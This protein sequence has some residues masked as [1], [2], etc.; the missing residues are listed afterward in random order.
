MQ[1][2]HHRYKIE[3]DFSGVHKHILEGYVK[4]AVGMKHFH[5]HFFYGVSSY[6]DHAHSY[7]GITGIPISTEKGH[8]HM[9]SGKLETSDGHKHTF[10]GYTFEDTASI[11]GIETSAYNI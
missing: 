2:H 6:L 11:T 4:N 3:S 9:I 10:K 1:I 5:F 7:T 8:I